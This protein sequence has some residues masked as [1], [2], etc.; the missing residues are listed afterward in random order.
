MYRTREI[1]WNKPNEIKLVII[2]LYVYMYLCF[3]QN[4]NRF[5][6]PMNSHSAMEQH[7]PTFMNMPE[8]RTKR[9][10]K[11]VMN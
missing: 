8:P 7:V 10:M 4:M 3:I 6:H 2:M 11:F 9:D 1:F 5:L